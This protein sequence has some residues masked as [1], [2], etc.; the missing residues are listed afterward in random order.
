MPQEK[1]RAITSTGGK[2][3]QIRKGSLAGD[4][5]PMSKG[6]HFKPAGAAQTHA[7]ATKVS[8]QV[9]ATRVQEGT[10][11]ASP[12]SEAQ[13]QSQPAGS[14]GL[15]KRGK[16]RGGGKA[17]P[18]SRYNQRYV[19][20]AQTMAKPEGLAFELVPYCVYAGIAVGAT[21][22]W[23]AVACTAGKGAASTS[24]VGLVLLCFVVVAGIA[25]AAVLTKLTMDSHKELDTVEITAAAVGR[26]ALAM[27]AAVLVWVLA[28]AVA[29][30]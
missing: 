15:A 18:Y 17:A 7:A 11:A 13:P 4:S 3:K 23:C 20:L 5:S 21:L 29:S 6:S 12:S 16:K 26:S 14:H 22:L 30:I 27:M 24:L 28:S 1:S 10:A 8:S 19:E 25:L 2:N 9:T